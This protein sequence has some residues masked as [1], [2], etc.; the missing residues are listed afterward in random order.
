MT[1]SS[2]SSGLHLVK[3]WPCIWWEGAG[4]QAWLACFGA[5]WSPPSRRPVS[6]AQGCWA[7]ATGSNGSVAEGTG[8]AGLAQ[9]AVEGRFKTPSCLTRLEVSTLLLLILRPSRSCRL[10]GSLLHLWRRLRPQLNCRLPHVGGRR[11]WRRSGRVGAVRLRL[12]GA[13][14]RARRGEQ[15]PGHEA[16]GWAGVG[17]GGQGGQVGGGRGS[18]FG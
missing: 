2:L 8:D 16:E 13:R 7:A 10:H 5:Q 15:G 12:A 3:G 1:P 18:C 4:W 9:R 6:R 14:R 11:R 17:R